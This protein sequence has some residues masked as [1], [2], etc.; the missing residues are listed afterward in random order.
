MSDSTISIN[1]D[2][3]AAAV[4]LIAKNREEAGDV[5]S[6]LSA[7]GVSVGAAYDFKVS[8]NSYVLDLKKSMNTIQEN[9]LQLHE[10]VT[11]TVTELGERDAELASQTETFLAGVNDIPAP[12]V[13]DGSTSTKVTTPAESRLN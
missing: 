5:R 9:L 11:K 10:N 8:L 2:D 1:P 4:N 13:A 7:T 3:A 6:Q 12:P